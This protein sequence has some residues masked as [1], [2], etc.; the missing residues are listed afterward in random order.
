MESLARSEAVIELGTQLV[1]ELSSDAG[2]LTQWMAH[3]IAS[4]ISNAKS[5]GPETQQS[6]REECSNAILSLWAHQNALPAHL[7]PFRELEPILRTLAALDGDNEDSYRHFPSFL[8]QAVTMDADEET[9]RWLTMAMGVDF[10]A[11]LLIQQALRSAGARSLS[12]IESWVQLAAN[13]GVD[14]TPELQAV[15]FLK[16]RVASKN[17]DE[18]NTDT[19]AARSQTIAKLR[20]FITIA[21]LLADRMQAEVESSAELEPESVSEVDEPEFEIAPLERSQDVN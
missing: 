7:Q 16:A 20:S 14:P 21:S 13:A 9:K 2:L 6:A 4:H 17:D 19:K 3:D 11:R 1:G 5:A 10:T 8:R 12:K 15:E 18:D